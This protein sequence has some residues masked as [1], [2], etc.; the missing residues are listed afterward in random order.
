MGRGDIRQNPALAHV[1]PENVSSAS[2]NYM[3]LPYLRQKG[4]FSKKFDVF[5]VENWAACRL[6]SLLISSVYPLKRSSNLTLIFSM[7]I[8]IQWKS[9]PFLV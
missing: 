2:S 6:S 8:L 5:G 4:S 1:Q 7:K 9:E 3:T